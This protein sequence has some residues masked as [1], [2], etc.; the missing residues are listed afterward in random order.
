MFV[1]TFLFLVYCTEEVDCLKYN[2]AKRS[3]VVILPLCPA[4]VKSHLEC[5]ASPYIRDGDIMKRV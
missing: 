1:V 4:V 3:G 2:V 5:W